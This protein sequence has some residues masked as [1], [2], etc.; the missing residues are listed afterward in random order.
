MNI[1]QCIYYLPQLH[2]HSHLVAMTAAWKMILS[3][4]LISR[5][6]GKNEYYLLKSEYCPIWKF[7]YLCS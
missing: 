2:F 6:K 1:K 3:L 7:L 5:K 4:R